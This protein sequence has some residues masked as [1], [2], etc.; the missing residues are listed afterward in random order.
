VKCFFN[1][2]AKWGWVVKV[3]TLPPCSLEREAV[4]IVQKAGLA[5]GPVWTGV[6]NLATTGIRSTYRLAS[7]IN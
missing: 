2:G 7:F 5:P 3:M 4:T 1:L 6:E